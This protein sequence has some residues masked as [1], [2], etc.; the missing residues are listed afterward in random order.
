M[1]IITLSGEAPKQHSSA[2]KEFTASWW[3][4]ETLRDWLHADGGFMPCI[5]GNLAAALLYFL[6]GLAVGHYFAAYGLFPAPIWLPSSVAVVAAMLGGWRFFP[7]L[8]LGSFLI[9]YGYFESSFFVAGLI[10]LTNALGPILAIDLMRR[11]RGERSLF[12]TFAGIVA[13]ILCAV[14]LHPAIT[15]GGGTLALNLGGVVDPAWDPDILFKTW[16]SWWLCDS[17]GTLSF[18]PCLLLWLDAERGPEETPRPLQRHERL[19]WVIVAAIVIG[20]FVA[21]PAHF[22]LFA[23]LPFLLVVPLSWIALSTSLRAAYTL[24][25]L[26]S[27]IAMAATAAGVGPFHAPVTINPLQMA[28]VLIVLFTMTVLTIVALFRERR[29]AEEATRA[30]SMLLATASH[31]LR[32]PLNAIIGFADLLRTPTRQML[33]LERVREYANDIHSSGSLLLGLIDEILDH[34]KIEA[35]KREIEPQFIDATGIAAACLDLLSGRAAGKQVSLAVKAQGANALFVDEL[36]MRQILLNLVGNA[37]KFTEAGGSVEVR[38]AIRAD[39]GGVVEV[40]DTGVGMSDEELAQVLL[41][42]EQAGST[43]QRQGGTGLGLTIVLRLV[44]MHGGRLSISSAPGQG[45]TV[46]LSF[47]AAPRA[48]VGTDARRT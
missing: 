39:G 36:A 12:S 48:I 6:L 16:T 40:A 29:A 25:S 15:A 8:F 26:A 1:S 45:T 7:G 11:W 43:R 24:V 34:A 38:L 2:H 41:P 5:G 30:K 10:S 14:I 33:T 47:P 17:G 19:V 32:T 3:N 13:F 27:V 23:T 37:V 18:A 42:F 9:N 4:K 28:G 46:R 21:P 35:G 20:L 31:D 44:E 22:A